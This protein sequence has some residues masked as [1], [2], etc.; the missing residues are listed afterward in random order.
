M[1]YVMN[2]DVL[3]IFDDNKEKIETTRKYMPQLTGLTLETNIVTAEELQA[4]P[5][6]VIVDDIEV[7]IDVPDYDI[8]TED[9]E[10]PIYKTVDV[11][12]EEG[13]VIGTETT[14]EIDHYEPAT[15]TISTP[16]MIDGEPYEDEEG[17]TITPQVQSTHKETIIVKG[18]VL[19]P[20]FEEEEATR[21]EA[22]FNKAFFN[23]SLGYI[24]RI[25]TN[26]DGSHA[27]FLYDIVP[28]IASAVSMGLS[29][30]LIVYSKPDF[31]EDITDWT[32]YQSLKPATPQ[33]IQECL[34]QIGN[35]FKPQ[36]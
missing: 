28:A 13:N 36:E 1:Y 35:D 16:V 25:I 6:K 32:P 8:T 30:N 15:R 7:E 24:R 17:N 23:T 22:E 10:E 14:D 26:A 9:Y 11:L 34:T 2:E 33:F 18:L 29:Y 19:N 12:D 21:R 3:S 4:H 27:N 5:N 31:T 20:D